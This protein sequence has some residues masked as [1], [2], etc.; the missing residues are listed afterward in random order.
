MGVDFLKS[1]CPQ[2]TKAWDTE[3]LSS[4]RN[5]LFSDASGLIATDLVFKTTGPQTFREGDEVLVRADGDRLNI[6]A[7]LAPAGVFAAPNSPVIEKIRESGG[8]AR[9]IIEA[10]YPTLDLVRVQIR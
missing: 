6:L 9:G 10:A 5:R 7:D 3:R 8:Y 4:S 2:F 1:K